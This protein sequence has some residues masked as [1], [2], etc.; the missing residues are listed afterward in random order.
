MPKKPIKKT[1]VKN[2]AVKKV[3]TKKVAAKKVMDEDINVTPVSH[4]CA[5]GKDCKCGCHTGC[6]GKFLRFIKWL[7]IIVIFFILGFATAKII[8]ERGYDA[9]AP[10]VDFED[11]CLVVESVRCPMMAEKLPLMDVNQDGCI[12]KEE[13][14]MFRQDCPRARRAINEV[15]REVREEIREARQEASEQ[16]REA[17]EALAE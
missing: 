10:R 14:N 2:N 11:G 9:R 5:C 1:T 4:E 15:K 13:F 3:A 17:S 8:D 16:L 7:L 6:G 12:S